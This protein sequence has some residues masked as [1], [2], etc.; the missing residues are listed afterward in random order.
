MKATLS[1]Y[2]QSP[3]KVA[4]VAGLIRGKKVSLALNALKF[5]T[6]RASNPIEK[7]LNSA[8]ANAKNAGVDKPED[9][10]VNE[11]R[12]DKGIILK[13]FMPRARGSSAPIWKRSSHIYLVLGDKPSKKGSSTSVKAES[14]EVKE[15]T[16]KADKKVKSAKK[17]V[18]AKK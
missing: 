3:R 1:N 10:Y 17:V 13:R 16:K 15:E 8:I 7:L 14:V 12:I 18:K 11:I 6:K 5:A 2:R 4:L 9:L